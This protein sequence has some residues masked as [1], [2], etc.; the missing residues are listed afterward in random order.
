MNFIRKFVSGKK[1]RYNEDGYDLDLTYI[2]PRVIAMSLPGEG[3]HKVYRNSINSVS[4]FLNYKHRGNFR[5]FNL[6]GIKYD[7]EKF[8][9]CVKEYPWADHYPPPI[10]LLFKA[11]NDIHQ[12]LELDL[13]NV[14]SIHCKAGKGRTGTLICCY[15]LYCGRLRNPEKALEFYKRKRFS[16]GG[17]VTQPSQVRYVY[18][19][20]DVL[21]KHIRSPNIIQ[22]G[23]IKMQTVPRMSQNSCRPIF[24][25]THNDRV[26]FS[27]RKI[28]KDKQSVL[29]DNWDNH[30]IY[31]IA[32]IN[33]ELLLQGDI[34][35]FLYHWGALKIKKICRFSFNTAF[36]DKGNQIVFE[37]EQLDPDNFRNNR[38]VSSEFKI[39]LET[40][41]VCNCTS[42]MLLQD[43][44]NLCRLKT[45]PIEAAKWNDIHNILL[46]RMVSDPSVTLFGRYED[47]IEA[48]L[49][50][51]FHESLLSSD[52]SSG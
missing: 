29:N 49:K 36:I 24:E 33:T 9:G 30:K 23:C 16:T 47:D 12:W 8:G 31:E 35:C 22:I 14:V 7:Y 13:K 18:Y 38:K 19:F 4:R 27:N 37:K 46:E 41:N 34:T 15:L 21:S 17:G 5:V 2:T 6:S 51:S 50:K 3:V 20:A 48:E 43:R 39:V 10:D 44:C 40:T 26:L 1:N 45:E 25:I 28:T 42:F 52:E 32:L 11:C